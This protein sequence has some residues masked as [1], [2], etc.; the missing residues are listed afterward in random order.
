MMKTKLFRIKNSILLKDKKKVLKRDQLQLESRLKDFN[1]QFS[2][3]LAQ[4]DAVYEDDYF[5]QNMTESEK[6]VYTK[7]Y[8]GKKFQFKNMKIFQGRPITP[9]FNKD[10]NTTPL[11]PRSI[12]TEEW[13]NTFWDYKR[14]G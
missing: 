10:D 1:D 6:E 9:A 11:N 4:W 5:I 14:P 3:D 13:S 12:S 7:I 8:V 2:K